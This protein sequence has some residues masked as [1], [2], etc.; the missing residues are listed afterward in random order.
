MA[1]P[2]SDVPEGR[3]GTGSASGCTQSGPAVILI[4]YDA[5]VSFRSVHDPE[6]GTTHTVISNS[7]DGTWPVTALLDDLLAT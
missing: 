7:S 6:T 5:G 4:G 2:R 3:C 1:R